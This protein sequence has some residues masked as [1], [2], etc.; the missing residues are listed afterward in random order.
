MLT[1]ILFVTG[2]A[3][4]G[5]MND[6]VRLTAESGCELPVLRLDVVLAEIDL[7]F[8][9]AVCRNLRRAR[10]FEASGFRVLPNLPAAEAVRLEVLARV[11]FDLW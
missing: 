3:R 11:S 5:L 10:A 1:G 8:P 6:P 7:R 4:V 9:R 2:S